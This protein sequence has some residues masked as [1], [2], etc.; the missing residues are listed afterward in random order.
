MVGEKDVESG[1]FYEHLLSWMCSWRVIILPLSG[2]GF[3]GSSDG[4]ESTCHCGSPE[5]DPWVGK[6]P[7]RRDWQPTPVFWPGE[8]HGQRSLYCYSSWSRKES[9]MAEQLALSGPGLRLRLSYRILWIWAYCFC[10]I[11]CVCRVGAGASIDTQ[12]VAMW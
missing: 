5:F 7:W 8:F 10:S 9:D 6:I 4:K 2:L 1:G 12:S 3:P 11:E